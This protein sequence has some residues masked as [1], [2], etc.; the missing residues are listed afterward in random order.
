MKW[1]WACLRERLLE[2]DIQRID[3][4]CRDEDPVM[5]VVFMKSDQLKEDFG[6][7]RIFLSWD[8]PKKIQAFML[9][10]AK[11]LVGTEVVELR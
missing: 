7:P 9:A 8:D 4:A 10:M 11:Y 1:P 3:F 2:E 6:E 5:E